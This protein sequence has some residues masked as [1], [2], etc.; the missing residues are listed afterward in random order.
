M[1]NEL[2]VLDEAAALESTAGDA[3]LAALLQTTCIE[4]SPKL[5]VAAR[6]AVKTGDWKN[7]R[8][9]GH[10]LRSSFAT[11]GAMAAAA[12]AHALEEITTENADDFL[13]AIDRVENAFQELISSLDRTVS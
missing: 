10:S 5:F 3:E 6:N 11:I 12:Q 1:L 7:V 13:A 9:Q 4:E 2:P 8:R